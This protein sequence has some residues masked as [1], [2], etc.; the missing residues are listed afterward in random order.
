MTTAA[1]AAACE[2]PRRRSVARQSAADDFPAYTLDDEQAAATAADGLPRVRVYRP[3][4]VQVVLGRGSRADVELRRDACRAD[5][6]PVTRRPGGGCAVVLDPGNLVV[7]ATIPQHEL[8]RIPELFARFSSWLLEGLE[9]V[10]VTGV[11]RE[12]AS[13]LVLGDR[14]IGGA[15]LY[16]P[17]GVALYATTLLVEPRVERMERYLAHPPREPGY[18]R[19][20][21][22]GEFVGRLA[23]AGGWTTEQLAAALTETLRPSDLPR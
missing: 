10:G 11:H 23:D 20:R 17:R 12:D 3:E 14:K 1:P 5:G 13:D 18:R 7:A 19:G 15:C 9:R 21:R 4:E 22:H 16:R 2:P 6:V 8:P